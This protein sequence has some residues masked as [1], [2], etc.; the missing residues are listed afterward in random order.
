MTSGT[1][2]VA[3]VCIRHSNNAPHYRAY[4]KVAALRSFS[5]GGMWYNS[6]PY[7]LK[8]LATI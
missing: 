3:A 4:S 2:H 7:W 5:V 1:N 6:V 8:L